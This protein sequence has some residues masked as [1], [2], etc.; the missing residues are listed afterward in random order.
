MQVSNHC[1]LRNKEQKLSFYTTFFSVKNRI[2]KSFAQ[3]F[4]Y[5]KALS[6]H[7]YSYNKNILWE[8]FLV[9]FLPKSR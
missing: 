5:K 6:L 2:N 8:V 3:R 9:P 1:F 4:F 7:I